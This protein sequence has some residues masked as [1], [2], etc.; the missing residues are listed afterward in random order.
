MSET[1]R[2][3]TICGISHPPDVQWKTCAQCGEKTDLIG[4][5]A[6]TITQEEAV[7][8]LRHREFEE[9][10]EKEDK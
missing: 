7:S 4:N 3:C 6:P 5:A 2:R 10:L 1:S 8:L 9:Y